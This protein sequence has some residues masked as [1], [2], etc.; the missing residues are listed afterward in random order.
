MHISIKNENDLELIFR[1]LGVT[2]FE[3]SSHYR[4]LYN[5]IKDIY[6]NSEK[7]GLNSIQW[8]DLSCN[9]KP[10]DWEIRAFVY[11]Q[12]DFIE[13]F[14]YI[15]DDIEKEK[16]IEIT[17]HEALEVIENHTSFNKLYWLITCCNGD[18]I[19][20]HKNI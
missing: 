6:R 3:N 1:A 7:Y 5:F 18:L 11:N 19:K 2:K 17:A 8:N 15:I 14:R 10:I 16:D 20:I 9:I 12:A 13:E 4:A